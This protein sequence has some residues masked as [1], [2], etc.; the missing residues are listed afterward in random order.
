MPESAIWMIQ[1]ASSTTATSSS[2]T[3]RIVG[4]SADVIFGTIVLKD[5]ARPV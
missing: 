2:T 1:D 4:T 5:V 3:V